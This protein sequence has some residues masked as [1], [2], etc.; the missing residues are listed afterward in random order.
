MIQ[1][2]S[3]I[4]NNIHNIVACK[5]PNKYEE[6]CAYMHEIWH[7]PSHDRHVVN[8][9]I[10]GGAD[11]MSDGDVRRESREGSLQVDCKRG[12]LL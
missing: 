11:A 3:N 5:K 10:D 8:L 4:S 1:R 6:K 2:Y 9:D 7:I 12:K